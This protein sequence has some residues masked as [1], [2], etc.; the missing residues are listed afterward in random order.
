[1][2]VSDFV[3]FVLGLYST[4][5]VDP[6]FLTTRP[7]RC[8]TSD[9]ACP[10]LATYLDQLLNHRQ[11]TGYNHSVPITWPSPLLFISPAILFPLLT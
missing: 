11:S 10:G 9:L 3:A 5:A 4:T 8:S 6:N 1:M 2:E 7:V